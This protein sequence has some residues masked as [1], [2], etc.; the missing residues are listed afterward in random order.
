[1]II[2][3]WLTGVVGPKWLVVNPPSR[4]VAA[5]GGWGKNRPDRRCGGAG[6]EDVDF[7]WCIFRRPCQNFAES[8][9]HIDNVR[10]LAPAGST[11][12]SS[13]E[14]YRDGVTVM[15]GA[16]KAA[17]KDVRARDVH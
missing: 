11:T 16:R 10:T 1:L 17:G 14:I 5:V 8:L 15:S 3:V 9:L 7:C 2:T 13:I 4:S 12:A 6:W